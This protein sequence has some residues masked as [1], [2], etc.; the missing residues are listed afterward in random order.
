MHRLNSQFQPPSLSTLCLQISQHSLFEK[1]S[2]LVFCCSTCLI[3]NKFVSQILRR[4]RQCQFVKWLSLQLNYWFH[5]NSSAL[6]TSLKSPINI[7]SPHS[8]LKYLVFH[9]WHCWIP[10]TLKS[11]IQSTQLLK[12]RVLDSSNCPK[13]LKTSLALL[14]VHGI[15]G[16]LRVPRQNALFIC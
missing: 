14:R 5:L 10:C 9:I 16:Q 11:S 7:L 2:I 6:L 4:S 3:R 15:N 8:T 13:S 1:S 12:S